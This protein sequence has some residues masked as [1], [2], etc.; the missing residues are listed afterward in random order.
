MYS[1]ADKV[2]GQGVGSAYEEQVNLVKE[3][4][5]DIFEVGINNWI[6]TPDIQHFHTVDP[7]F[8]VKMQN[9]KAANVAYCHFLPDTLEGSLKIPAPLLNVFRSYLIQYLPMRN[10][11]LRYI[12]HCP[13][14][15]QREAIT[16]VFVLVRKV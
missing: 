7:T 11:V 12:S 15:N 4:A 1:S 2:D 10:P 16:T 5:S 6:K 13:V 14:T 8:F 9:H 3:G